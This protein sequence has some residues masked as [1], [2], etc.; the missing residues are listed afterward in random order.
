MT[1]GVIEIDAPVITKNAPI[2]LEQTAATSLSQAKAAYTL[3]M[4][5]GK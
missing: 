4:V 3:Q 2:N 1:A 5:L